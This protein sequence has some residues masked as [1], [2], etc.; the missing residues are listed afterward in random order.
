MERMTDSSSVSLLVILVMDKE[1]ETTQNR[2]TVKGLRISSYVPS[3]T[4][5]DCVVSSGVNRLGVAVPTESLMPLGR[6]GV[7][8]PSG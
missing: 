5:L 6:A 1:I 7:E 2:E 3:L 8:T 4:V